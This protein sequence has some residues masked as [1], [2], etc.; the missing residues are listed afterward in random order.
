MKLFENRLK[1][2]F[3]I[4]LRLNFKIIYK[5]KVKYA[6][7]TTGDSLIYALKPEYA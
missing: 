4:K 6:I 1:K 3:L 7:I 2:H 5:S